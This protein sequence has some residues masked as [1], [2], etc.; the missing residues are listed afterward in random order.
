MKYLALIF[1]LALFSFTSCKKKELEFKFT[2]NIK[3]LNNNSNLANADVK[4]YVN[5]AG[6]A[7]QVLEATT[8]SDNSGNYEVSIERSKYE[9]VTIKVSKSNYFNVEEAYSIDDL[10][11]SDPN[12]IDYSLSPKSWTKFILKNVPAGNSGDV[13]KIQKVS[14]KT[15]CDDC[16]PNETKFY[17]GVIDEVVYCP[18][19][20]DTYMKFFWF[21]EGT[22]T[23]NG[24]DSIYNTPFDTISY[25]IEY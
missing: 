21:V 13:L 2:G 3:S 1:L 20:G 19:D 25:T 23:M 24:V 5:T 15:N 11:T 18:N 12:E 8:T 17:Y 6:S 7:N 10:T 9:T 16:C 4:I 14:G 22:T